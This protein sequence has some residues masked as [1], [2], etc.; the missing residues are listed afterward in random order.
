MTDPTHDDTINWNRF[1]TEADEDR[2][3]S[4]T[5]SAHHVRGLLDDFFAEKGVPESFADVGCGPGVVARHVA[6]QYPETTVVGYDAAESALADAREQAG[7]AGLDNLAFERGVLPDFDPGRAF[8][9]VHCFGTLA[10]VADSEPALES[11]YDAVAPG[12]HLVLGYMNDLARAHHREMV[13]NPEEHPDPDFDPEA[14]A[15]R[16]RLVLD[17]ESTLSYRDI[18]DAVGT[19]PRSFWE[20]T[21]KPDK[22]WA[23]RHVP[24]VWLPK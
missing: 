12:G 11:L 5:P 7:A 24:L 23:W 14:F 10:Y 22:R 13:E 8:D 20:V 1:W 6:E 4:A 19:W 15:D 9:L 17:G 16:F 21:D 3:A 18:H 2:R